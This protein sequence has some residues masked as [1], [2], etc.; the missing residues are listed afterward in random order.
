MNYYTLHMGSG[1]LVIE[2]IYHKWV[3]SFAKVKLC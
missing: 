3:E 2:M 1:S